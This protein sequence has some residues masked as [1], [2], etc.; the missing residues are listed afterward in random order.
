MTVIRN[1]AVVTFAF[2]LSFCVSASPRMKMLW[3]GVVKPEAINVYASASTSERVT[4]T[5][6]QGDVVEV[7]L[8]ITTSTGD[9][10][11]RVELAGAS[12]PLGFVLC[13]NLE[14][15]NST[16]KQTAHSERVSAPPHSTTTV[17]PP[18]ETTSVSGVLTNN[19]ILDMHKAG[20]PPNVLVA[21]IKASQC[22]FD[23]SPSQLKQLKAEGLTDA[24]IL[25]MVEAPTGQP[26]PAT[27]AGNA[28]NVVA[29]ATNAAEPVVPARNGKAQS[30]PAGSTI[31]LE[32]RGTSDESQMF[33]ELLREKLS[34]DE[35]NRNYSKPGFPVVD[36]KEDAAYTLRFIFVLRENEK[37]FMENP[38]EH[39]RVNVWLVNSTDAV[40]WEHNYDCVRIFREPARECYQHISDDL[41]AA[42]VNAQGKRAGLLGWKK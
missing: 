41:K 25:A 6:K 18:F 12:E 30:I 34:K 42:Q 24:V 22:G 36:K 32:N 10:W 31:F 29:G 21:K 5:L 2:A 14:R 40:V 7:V 20:L 15:K 35:S 33:T 27:P 17:A 39:A 4:G 11:C 1:S 13:L 38:Q 8:Q 37:G 19:D 16:T 26:K 28:S 23:T 3:Q 9:S